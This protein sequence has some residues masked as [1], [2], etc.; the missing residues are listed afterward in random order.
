MDTCCVVTSADGVVAVV[1][2]VDQSKVD[3]SWT[4]ACCSR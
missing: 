2:E 3:H 1:F 4:V